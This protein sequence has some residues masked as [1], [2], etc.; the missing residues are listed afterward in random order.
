MIDADLLKGRSVELEEMK[1]QLQ[2]LNTACDRRCIILG[3]TGGVGKTQLAIAYARRHQSAY[4]SIF[5]LNATSE[6]TLNFSFRRVAEIVFDQQSVTEFEDEAILEG[7]RR[8]LSRHDNTSWLMI[9]DNYDKPHTYEI[10]KY[11]P[12]ATYGSII[13]TTRL[14]SQVQG[15]LIPVQPLRKIEDRLAVLQTRSRRTNVLS[16]KRESQ[17]SRP[18][19]KH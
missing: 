10:E 4:S 12:T 19:T 18:G 9:F 6:A 16:G 17:Y 15:Y 13:V 1:N 2:V 14:S 5:W 7:V 3:G 8:W 11:Y